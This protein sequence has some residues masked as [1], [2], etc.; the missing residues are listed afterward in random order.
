MGAARS[1]DIFCRVVDN[2]GDAAVCWRL[3]RQLAL[4]HGARVRLWIDR[5]AT[6]RALQPEPV[7]PGVDIRCWEPD[8]DFGAPADIA[9]DA[10]DAGLP[11]RYAA[12]MPSSSL[13]IKL[14]Y[15]SAESWVDDHHG[16]PSPHPRLAVPRYFFF[17]G[18]TP[19]TGGL[20]REAGLLARRD[21]F[22][23]GAF[24]ATLGEAPPESGSLVVSLFGYE[25]PAVG[26]LL[27]AWADGPRPIV[28]AVAEGRLKPEVAAFFGGARRR[29]NLEARFLPFLPQAR[30]DELLWA[31]DWNFV[32]GEDSFVRAQWAARP[33]VWQIYPQ[34][35]D[36][37]LAKLDAFLA[38]YCA[39]LDA[40]LAPLW[41]AWNRRTPGVVT[42]WR[43]LEDRQPALGAHARAWAAG[44]AMQPELA[45][46][47]ARFSEN[48]LK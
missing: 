29:G 4:E 19:R 43:A 28:V 47:L 32:R 33:F 24:W 13:W 23:P 38:L 8:A 21:A 22:E 36:A 27:R 14:E 5:P 12:R 18:F 26:D 30:Y 3:A 16:L 31:C 44:L 35:D 40:P 20:L 42:A 10:F 7:G 6:L 45:G 15:L 34:A 25:N 17:P 2:Y 1:W 41:Q 48:L 46:N 11:E 9:L 39:G 37:H